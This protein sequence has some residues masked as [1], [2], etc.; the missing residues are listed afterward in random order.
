MHEDPVTKSKRVTNS[1]GT[2]VSTVELDPWG[3]D[4]SRSSNVA[5]Q[6]KKFTS[7]ERDANGTDEAMF[8]R[9]NRWQSRFDQPD[10]YEGSYS[11][12]NP[13]SFNRYAYTQGDPANFVDPTGLDGEFTCKQGDPTCAVGSVTIPFNWDDMGG[14][15]PDWSSGSG[16]NFGFAF[17]IPLIP[18]LPEPRNTSHLPPQNKATICPPVEF[19]VTGIAPGQAP[20]KTA[21]SQQERADIPDG[22]VAIKPGNFGVKGINGNNRSVFLNMRFIVDWSTAKP[23]GAPRGIPTEGP[24]QPVDNIGPASVRNSPGNMIDVYNYASNKDALASTRTVMVT[25]SIP[26]NSVGVTCPN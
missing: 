18:L 21:I 12:T 15:L 3:A 19:K 26:V 4:T 10:P 1:A 9:Y 13:Q 23:A 8:R 22:G 16:R 11:L 5:F 24:F 14:Y 6:P 25:T 2:V 17:M 7:Y 20:G